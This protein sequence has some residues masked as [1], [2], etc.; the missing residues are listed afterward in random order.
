MA[1]IEPTD[2]S[3][4]RWGP[5]VVFLTV[6]F[7]VL[8]AVV[9]TLW[10]GA[11]SFLSFSPNSIEE[12]I[13]GWGHWGVVGSMSLMVLHS[14]VPFPAEFLAMANG[15]VYGVIWGIVITWSGAML[16]AFLAFALARALGRP[17]VAM[18]VSRLNW[19]VIDQWTGEQGWQVVF[20]S[21]F[22]PVIAFNLVNYIAG[23]TR[24]SWW[25]FGWTTGFGILPLTILM[26]M[27]DDRADMLPWY[28]WAIL[29]VIGVVLWLVLLNRLRALA[30]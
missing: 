29:I 6:I 4:V 25:T 28:L 24:I 12:Q 27:V 26:V 15:M 3:S 5:R 23:L 20:L 30:L 16:G 21:R 7:V 14:F 1:D 18:V 10:F 19:H 2:P 11:D 8:A 22:L 9:Y 13:R 17:F